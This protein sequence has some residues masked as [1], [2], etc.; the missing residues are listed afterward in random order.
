ML[1]EERDRA[2]C[3]S[4]TRALRDAGE[5]LIA[6][7]NRAGGRDNITVVL[8]RLEEF[9][10][11]PSGR[12]PPSRRRVTGAAG[13]DRPGGDSPGPSRTARRRAAPVAPVDG[14]PA[15]RSRAAAR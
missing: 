13:R 6:A 12:R 7:A 5:A 4:H 8:L 3:C 9:E 10:V 15:A 2:A 14:A 11:R 1:A